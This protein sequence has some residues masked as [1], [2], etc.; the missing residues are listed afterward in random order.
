MT[1]KCKKFSVQ[2]ENSGLK[3]GTDGML[4]GAWAD[5]H[6]FN[7][8]LDV[9]TGSGLISLMLAQR[10]D[11]PMIDAIDI[12]EGAVIDA[13]YNFEQSEWKSRLNVLQKNFT[14][15]H[16]GKY[17][18]IVSNPPFF[19]KSTKSI[20]ES[21][22]IAKH[23]EM[24]SAEIIIEYA[25]SFENIKSIQFVLP[26]STEEEIINFAKSFG[27]DLARI[28][29]IK[30]FKSEKANRLLIDFRR[31]KQPSEK[32]QFAI[33]EDKLSKEYTEEYIDLLKDFLII[34]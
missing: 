33:R 3:V 15:Y 13:Q 22:M 6:N 19:N 26:F 21:K 30:P 4:L 2:D 24:L 17:D 9:G 5:V 7:N 18:C 12:F 10:F 27:W 16:L 11:K 29:Q 25:S 14:N 34:F 28:C 32:K 8:V 31:L 1:F 23:T 20:T